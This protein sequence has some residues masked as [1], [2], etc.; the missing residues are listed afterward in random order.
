MI[1]K[2]F[3]LDKDDSQGNPRLVA[4]LQEKM[5]HAAP[6]S[7]PAAVI[8]P[9]GGFTHLSPREAEPIAM[10]FAARGYQTFVLYYSLK[11]V[12]YPKPL[13]DAA[14]AVALVREHA[15]EWDICPDHI[16]IGGFSAGGHV[17][18]ALATFWNSH[19]ITDAGLEPEKVR[20]N[21]VFLGYSVLSAGTDEEH[22]TGFADRLLAEKTN[23]PE[24]RRFAFIPHNVTAD[25]PPTFLWHTVTDQSV[26]V[27]NPLWMAEALTAVKV[28]YELHIFPKGAHGTALANEYT[29][30][31][32][33]EMIEPV[34][35]QWVPLCM[36]WLART[37]A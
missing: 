33:P 34:V 9:G 16:V 27:K 19:F 3:F 26:P 14:R 28:P 37:F 31:G 4:Y 35:T 20:P 1:I 8:C 32:K 21:A 11:P 18:A 17:S 23:D 5:P 24:M 10:T 29:A 7:F 15:E 12:R 25:N 2:E 6:G 22:P 36:D 13:L 30:D